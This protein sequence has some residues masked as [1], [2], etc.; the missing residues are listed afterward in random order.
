M[1]KKSRILLVDD[2][3]NIRVLLTAILQSKGYIVDCAEDGFAA[4]HSIQTNLPDL[5]VSD[6]RMPNMNG[7]ELLAVVR[8]KFPEM[9][10]IA[11]SGEFVG[12][13][14][15][16]GLADAFFQKAHYSPSDLLAAVENLLEGRRPVFSGEQEIPVW[17]PTGDAPVMLTCNECL[18]S[19]PI[20]P[21]GEHR[22]NQNEIQCIFCGVLLRFRLLA[23]T[24]PA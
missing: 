21:C 12:E 1:K 2:E 4:L 23:V 10:I 7:F 5:I 8:N 16:G 24:K 20:D 22:N 11:I 17:A 14:I 9:P 6:L 18:R 13:R 15:E 19:F 3:P